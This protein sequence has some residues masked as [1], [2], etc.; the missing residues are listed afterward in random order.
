MRT[1]KISNIMAFNVGASM[2]PMEKL[3]VGADVWY[4]SLAEDDA[5]GENYLG[6]ELDLSASYKVMDNLNS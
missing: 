3:T 1:D 4:A 2:S 6:T 5:A